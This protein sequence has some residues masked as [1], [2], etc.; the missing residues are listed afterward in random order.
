MSTTSGS[1]GTLTPTSTD[2]GSDGSPTRTPDRLSPT[3]IRLALVVSAI[4]IAGFVYALMQP[5]WSDRSI[6]EVSGATDS[7]TLAVTVNHNEC[8]SGG[9]RVRVT[10]QSAEFVV[11]HAEQ[12]ERGDCHDVGLTSVVTVDLEA[13]LG[14]RQFRFD[15]KQGS[16]SVVCDIDG[17]AVNQC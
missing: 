5:R 8:G 13:P 12:N 9:P 15:P 6:S 7:S 3:S 10:Q 16:D 11:L 14:Q 1:N 2:G 17:R 4:V